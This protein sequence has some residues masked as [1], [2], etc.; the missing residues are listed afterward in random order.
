MQVTACRDYGPFSGLE[1]QSPG[2]GSRKNLSS[3]VAVRTQSRVVASFYDA[4]RVRM[5]LAPNAARTECDMMIVV[6][7][8]VGSAEKRH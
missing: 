3:S 4:L 5:R 8:V 6:I 1:F 7:W 2:K